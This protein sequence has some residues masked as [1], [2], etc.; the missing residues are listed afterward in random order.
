MHWEGGHRRGFPVID[1]DDPSVYE[2]LLR[3]VVSAE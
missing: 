2:Q 1:A 3:R